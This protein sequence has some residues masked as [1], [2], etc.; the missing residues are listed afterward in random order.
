MKD[1]SIEGFLEVML[2]SNVTVHN[3]L[4]K[5]RT[6]LEIQKKK[7]KFLLAQFLCVS[8]SVSVCLYIVC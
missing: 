2:P 5:I 6:R 4:L 3:F 1:S 8:V 7:N